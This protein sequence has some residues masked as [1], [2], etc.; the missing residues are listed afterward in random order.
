MSS[1]FRP[2]LGLTQQVKTGGGD[3]LSLQRFSLFVRHSDE[4]MRTECWAR[5][6]A[7]PADLDPGGR[8]LSVSASCAV[9]DGCITQ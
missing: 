5:A 3:P 1:G 4:V 9:L 6:L 2:A 8:A 7:F